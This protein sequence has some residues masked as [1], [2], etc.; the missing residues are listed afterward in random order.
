MKVDRGIQPQSQVV[1]GSGGGLSPTSTN[2][3]N[4]KKNKKLKI[5]KNFKIFIISINKSLKIFGI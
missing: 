1:R 5:K 3:K 2:N 4:Q